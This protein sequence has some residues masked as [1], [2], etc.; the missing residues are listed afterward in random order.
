MPFSLI[1]SDSKKADQLVRRLTQGRYT[2][3]EAARFLCNDREGIDYPFLIRDLEEFVRNG[4]IP[5]YKPD[6]TDVAFI[7]ADIHNDYGE[8]YWNDLNDKWLP[9]FNRVKK[10]YPPPLVQLRPNKSYWGHQHLSLGDA[11]C[12]SANISPDW[13][14]YAKDIG[15]VNASKISCGYS[16][17]LTSALRWAQ[18]TNCS[19]RHN[20]PNRFKVTDQVKLAEFAQWVIEEN[21]DW[22]VPDEFRALAKLISNPIESLT[23]DW[24]YWHLMEPI[25]LRSAIYLS[26]NINPYWN[27]FTKDL[28]R[29][30][31][32]Q[33]RERLSQVASRIVGAKWAVDKVKPGLSVEHTKIS[34]R[35]F[36]RWF[37]DEMGN[38]KRPVEFDALATSSGVAGGQELPATLKGIT[39][40]GGTPGSELSWGLRPLV[41][42]KRMPGYR[43][44]LYQTLQ[45]MHQEGHQN[46]PTPYEILESWR[47]E[48]KHEQP[49]ECEIWV[50]RTA[51]EFKNKEGK[52]KTVDTKALNDAIQR[53][54]TT[55]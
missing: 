9:R 55:H 42:I 17:R 14:A 34:L 30:A 48:F 1:A 35:L 13:A 22:V 15:T 7:P 4:Q 10:R 26:L 33:Y 49:N 41:D 24:A 39:Q 20:N 50:H 40:V 45:K 38:L 23:P 3:A 5:F 11:I 32:V 16:P 27:V 18:N 31:L 6:I 51:F 36:V 12:L 47:N 21:S 46:V 52:R 29:D 53:L 25:E 43:A 54:I 44:V 2:I 28:D 8:V 19:W 37:C